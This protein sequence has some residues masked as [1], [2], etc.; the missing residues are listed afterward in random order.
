M[1]QGV[2]D[3]SAGIFHEPRFYGQSYN[4]MLESLFAVPLYKL[5]IPIYKALP[6]ITSFFTI[7]PYLLI[8]FLT[9]RKKSTTA[10]LI[11]LSIPLLLLNEYA[12]ITCLSR[13]FVTGIF[14]GEPNSKRMQISLKLL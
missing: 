9:F 6:I 13:G 2:M 12:L 8:T 1:W 5:G 4:L 10:G 7:F 3:Y 11:I 14:Q